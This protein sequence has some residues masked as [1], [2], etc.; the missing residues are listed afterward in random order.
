MLFA[1]PGLKLGLTFLGIK[2][3]LYYSLFCWLGHMWHLVKN[4][5]VSKIESV[6]DTIF[7]VFSVVYFYIIC[8]VNLY[9]T[10][11]TVLEI[12]PRLIASVCDV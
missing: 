11:D 6:P 9:L 7:A 8:N 1:I 2:Y 4:A 3:V 12:L 5:N 10:G